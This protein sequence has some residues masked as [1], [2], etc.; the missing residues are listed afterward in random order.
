MFAKYNQSIQVE[1]SSIIWVMGYD[2]RKCSKSMNRYPDIVITDIS[3]VT[4]TVYEGGKIQSFTGGYLYL[5]E[6]VPRNKVNARCIS[7]IN[8][9]YQGGLKLNLV[10]H[11]TSGQYVRYC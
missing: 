4:G 9:L 5:E 10:F 3:E 8:T 7:M 2:L 1:A 11:M 6:F